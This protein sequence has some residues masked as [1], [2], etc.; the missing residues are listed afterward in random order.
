MFEKK[1]SA[2]QCA[3]FAVLPELRWSDALK[4]YLRMW[5]VSYFQ[6]VL[7]IKMYTSL[8]KLRTFLNTEVLEFSEKLETCGNSFI[9]GQPHIFKDL[10][11]SRTSNHSGQAIRLGQLQISKQCSAL[12]FCNP[13]GRESS[14]GQVSR[15]KLRR[16]ERCWTPSAKESRFGQNIII[17]CSSNACFSNSKRSQITAVFNRQSSKGT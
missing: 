2:S 6:P 14:L 3:R 15:I 8:L 16:A 11:E 1:S 17:K 4:S 9:P 5:D 10:R 7:A 13:S 12:T